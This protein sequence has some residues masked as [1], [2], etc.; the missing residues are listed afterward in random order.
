MTVQAYLQR[1]NFFLYDC[2][3]LMLQ[4]ISLLRIGKEEAMK[5]NRLIR[6]GSVGLI[7]S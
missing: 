3:L 2:I 7:I 1:I 4:D 5:H 6:I